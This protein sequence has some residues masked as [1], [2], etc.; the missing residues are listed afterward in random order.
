MTR[1]LW[2]WPLAIVVLVTA[3][4]TPVLGAPRAPPAG[5]AAWEV[6]I[7]MASVAPAPAVTTAAA[8]AKVM[9]PPGTAAAV[10]SM[11]LRVAAQTAGPRC[12]PNGL[13]C[14]EFPCCSGC[15]SSDIICQENEWDVG[16]ACF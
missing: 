8:A 1:L 6:P 16:P 4:T 2:L 15:C 3:V 12:V 10:G 5:D 14:W 9:P 11:P 7:A 13:P